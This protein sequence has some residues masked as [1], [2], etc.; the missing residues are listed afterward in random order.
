MILDA[1]KDNAVNDR[2]KVRCRRG[3]RDLV[4]ICRMVALVKVGA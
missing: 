1:I 3:A 4:E 2:V